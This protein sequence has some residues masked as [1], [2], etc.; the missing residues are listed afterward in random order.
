M[1]SYTK[2][3]RPL[4]VTPEEKLPHKRGYTVDPKVPEALREAR[5]LAR[6]RWV[7][8]DLYLF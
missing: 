3:G 5:E 6:V 4:H 2:G 7:L 8:T 1:G